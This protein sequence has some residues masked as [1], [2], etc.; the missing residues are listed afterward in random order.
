[1]TA[2]TDQLNTWLIPKTR[3]QCKWELSTCSWHVVVQNITWCEEIV[4]QNAR[5]LYV[6]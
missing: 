5:I 4:S 6:L 1:M 2:K 3:S